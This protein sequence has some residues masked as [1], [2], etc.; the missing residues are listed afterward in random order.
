MTVQRKGTYVGAV[1]K[2]DAVREALFLSGKTQADV[3]RDMGITPQR[4]S[5]V[6]HGQEHPG[7]KWCQRFMETFGGNFSD[8]FV[9][10]GPTA[11]RK[12]RGTC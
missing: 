10:T 6:L 4:F 5:S 7:R 11:Q 9:L 1:I 3:A 2:A 8:W 12:G